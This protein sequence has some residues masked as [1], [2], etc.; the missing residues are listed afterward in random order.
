M[1]RHVFDTPPPRPLVTLFSPRCHSAL[2]AV[3]AAGNAT[4]SHCRFFRSL[5]YA[6]VHYATP[7]QRLL[8]LLRMFARVGARAQVQPCHAPPCRA[9]NAA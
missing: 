4:R 7:R 1:F 3:G 6:R 2:R 9:E 5:R 8:L